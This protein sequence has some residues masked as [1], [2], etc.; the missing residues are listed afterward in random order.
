[1]TTES[2]T[3]TL[4]PY[5]SLGS[6]GNW[7]TTSTLVGTCSISGHSCLDS[8]QY[9]D[10]PEDIRKVGYMKKLKVSNLK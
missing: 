5:G 3:S 10:L 1:M 4:V 6:A 9:D 2:D 8:E 7:S